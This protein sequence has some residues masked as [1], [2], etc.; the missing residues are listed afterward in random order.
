MC[1]FTRLYL[2][3]NVL[4]FCCS[5]VFLILSVATSVVASSGFASASTLV[6]A[7]MLDMEY[8]F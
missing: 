5:V 6:I 2:K 1:I 4:L 3:Y 7:S 8:L